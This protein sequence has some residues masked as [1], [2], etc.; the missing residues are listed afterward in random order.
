MNIELSKSIEAIKLNKRTGIPT[1]EPPVTIPFGAV[2]LDVQQDR[3]CDNF[4]FLGERY[5]CAHDVL[6]A[7]VAQP[8]AAAA[9]IQPESGGAAPQAFPL[10]P[11][12]VEWEEV[13]SSRSAMARARVPG[14]WLVAVEDAGVTFYPDPEHAWSVAT[15]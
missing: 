1:N 7:A 14:G 5:R 6:R 10:T 11:S 8:A 12:E 13:K 4:T 2:V 9:A 15:Q 3:D